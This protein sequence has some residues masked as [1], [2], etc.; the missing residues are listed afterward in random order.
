MPARSRTVL[1]RSFAVAVAAL[2]A[3]A[4]PG[5]AQEKPKGDTTTRLPLNVYAGAKEGDW[6]TY[7][8]TMKVTGIDEVKTTQMTWR[9]AS[10]GEDGAVKVTQ[11]TKGREAH[12]HR[13]NPFSTKEA[14]TVAKFCL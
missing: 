4:A 9:V 6:S 11:E 10:V 13:G 1:E 14:P 2:V 3:V 12:E 8:V 5:F 7:V